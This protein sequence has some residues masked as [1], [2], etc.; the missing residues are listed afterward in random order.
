METII[1]KGTACGA[2]ESSGTFA[3]GAIYICMDCDGR[4]R[5]NRYMESMAVVYNEQAICPYCRSF[6][7]MPEPGK[8][9]EPQW[10]YTIKRLE[11]KLS[12]I[13]VHL[14]LT[15]I[16]AP[17]ESERKYLQKIKKET[18]TRLRVLRKMEEIQEEIN[19]GF[20]ISKAKEKFYYNIL[21]MENHGCSN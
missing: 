2:N 10:W 11:E 20:D 18:I 6:N 19:L 4:F 1:S 15:G 17:S 7:C 9:G 13:N 21:K 16:F 12:K 8:D 14:S 3:C 5:K